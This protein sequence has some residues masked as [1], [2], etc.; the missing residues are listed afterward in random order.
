MR[1]HRLI[2]ILLLVESRGKMK[3]ND[4]AEA[5]ETSVRSIYRDIDVLAEAGIPLLSTPDRMVASP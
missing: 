1:L 5:L 3:A 4:L 2:A